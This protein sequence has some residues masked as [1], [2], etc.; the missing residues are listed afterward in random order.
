[1]SKIDKGN[2]PVNPHDDLHSFDGA[3]EG[4][5]SGMNTVEQF[6]KTVESDISHSV[7]GMGGRYQIFFEYFC[8][9]FGNFLFAASVNIVI[10]PLGLYNGGFTGIA[11]LIKAFI[12]GYAGMNMP[13]W[14]DFTGIFNFLLNVPL[15]IYSYRILGKK[16]ALNN[17]LSIGLAS[18]FL[19]FIPV[20]KISMFDEYLTACVVGG[21]VGGIGSGLMLRGGSSSGGADI[22]AMCRIKTHPNA[23]VGSLNMMINYFVYGVC[24]LAFNVQ[25]AVYSFIYAA[26]K[27]FFV[28]RM[29]TQNI[30]MEVLI[31]TK[32]EGIDKAINKELGRGVTKWEGRGSYTNDRVHVLVSAIS[33]YEI[34]HLRSLVMEM[35][36]H[37][38]MI[39]TEGERISGN[40][41][42][43][44]INE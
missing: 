34:P 44:L 39:S 12:V 25:T 24:L 26:V 8:V 15:L 7:H 27:A 32:I 19:A 35:D 30:N 16:F 28:D 17:L 6:K 37:A 38:F 11:Q 22:I 10:A 1:M 18:I 13:P 20:P 5:E 4:M 31:F 36:P 42:K 14:I 41:K 43:H 21:F 9:I 3:R 40:F 23:S 2:T 33:K 29:H